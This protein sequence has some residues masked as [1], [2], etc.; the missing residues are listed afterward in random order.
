M[1]TL[2]KITANFGR[3]TTPSP[4]RNAS[5]RNKTISTR[6]LSSNVY[7]VD[8]G[9]NDAARIPSMASAEK[10]IRRGNDREME[11]AK[12]PIGSVTQTRYGSK[13]GPST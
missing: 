5:G 11:T 8:M 6:G 10:N 9:I 1:N 3:R 13:M 7:K 2:N 4:P 12:S